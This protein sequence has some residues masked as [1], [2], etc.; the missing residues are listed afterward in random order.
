M[1]GVI[2]VPLR[3][4]SYLA[5][6]TLSVDADHASVRPVCVTAEAARFVGAVGGVVSVQALVAMSTEV[7]PDRCPA[8]SYASTP[9]V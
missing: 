1:D 5:T 3:V 8:A 7:T 6:P 4:T 9:R 2:C